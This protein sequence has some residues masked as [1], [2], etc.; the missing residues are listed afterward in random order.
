MTA[1]LL[2]LQVLRKNYGNPIKF[3]FYI[4]PVIV[5]SGIVNLDFWL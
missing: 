5:N 3:R 2:V 1:S 4:T